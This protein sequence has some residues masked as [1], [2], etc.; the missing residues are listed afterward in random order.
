M[1]DIDHIPVKDTNI[2]GKTL[3][4]IVI[5]LCKWDSQ[6]NIFLVMPKK[7]KKMDTHWNCS[8]IE[9]HNISMLFVQ[10][11]EKYFVIVVFNWQRI[12]HASKAVIIQ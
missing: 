7:K 9:S 11:V 1:A 8:S 10:K 4:L 5:E 12:L 3:L 2:G 6:I